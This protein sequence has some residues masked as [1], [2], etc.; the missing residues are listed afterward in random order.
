[1]ATS[2]AQAVLTNIE[3]DT[4]W[5]WANNEFMKGEVQ[6]ALNALEA[7]IDTSNFGKQVLTRDLAD[8]KKLMAPA[9][10]E[11]ELTRWPDQIDPLVGE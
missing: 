8:V 2:Q 11:T 1:M 7:F 10:F 4:A 3:K 6:K 5:A 9:E